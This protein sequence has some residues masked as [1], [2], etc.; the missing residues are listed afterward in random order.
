[1][2]SEGGRVPRVVEA[3]GQGRAVAG[4]VVDH[5]QRGERD[6]RDSRVDAEHGDEHEV[7][8]AGHVVAG[9]LGLLGHV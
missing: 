3:F 1:M 4:G 9:V 8:R 2:A 5:G 6:D 7:D